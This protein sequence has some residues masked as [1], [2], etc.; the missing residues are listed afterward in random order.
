MFSLKFPIIDKIVELRGNLPHNELFILRRGLWT[1]DV[2][3]LKA[4][5]PAK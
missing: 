5:L 4:M 3:T 1:K 2:P